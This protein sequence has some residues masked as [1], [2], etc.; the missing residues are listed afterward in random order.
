MLTVRLADGDRAAHS[1]TFYGSK[2]KPDAAV[3]ESRF[4][5]MVDKTDA[6]F[7]L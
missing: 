6:F 2:E 4:W 7:S 5:G 3:L 1:V